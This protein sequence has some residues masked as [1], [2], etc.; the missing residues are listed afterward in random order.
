MV[1]V[2]QF[3]WQLASRIRT[4]LSE[5]SLWY[6]NGHTHCCRHK[7]KPYL[8]LP[9]KV[10]SN[11][12]CRFPSASNLKHSSNKTNKMHQFLK[13]VFG[14]KLYLFRTAPLSITRNFSLYTQKWYMSYRF[15]DSLRAVPLWSCSQAVSKPLWHIPLLCVQWKTPDNGQRNC[16]K[17]VEFYF[18][19]KF[20][21]LV[22]L[23]GFII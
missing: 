15:S 10:L 14:I 5:N 2:I 18:K 13:F 11:I 6:V 8:L 17:H 3:C 12:S 16:Q 7:P 19:N 23:A 4:Q 1:Y 20:E 9:I 22:H 21:K